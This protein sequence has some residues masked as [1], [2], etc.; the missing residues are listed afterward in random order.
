M[1][2]GIRMQH[3]AAGITGV[4]E[5]MAVYVEN[6]TETRF[7]FHYKQ[8]IGRAVHTV[9]EDKKIP[10]ELDVNVMV[11][12]AQRMRQI[13]QETRGIDSVTDVLSFPYFEFA[14]PGVFDEQLQ[15]WADEDI[16]G[17]IVLCA[18]R[19]VSQAEEYGHS[20]KR[21]MAFLVVHS[22]LHLTGYDH[23]DDADAQLMETEQRR[24]MEI[25]GI[26]RD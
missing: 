16:L 5:Y 1:K 9:I 26:G 23:M 14:Q 15:D 7:P 19:I 11:V 18:E 20:Q 17:D 13:N 25:L 22:M 10:P 12:D 2:S 8:L 21:E 6:Q 4:Y 3:K 24:I